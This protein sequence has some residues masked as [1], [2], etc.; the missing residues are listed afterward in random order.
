VCVC[1]SHLE[2]WSK[3]SEHFLEG[4]ILYIVTVKAHKERVCVYVCE[5]ELRGLKCKSDAEMMMFLLPN[6][7]VSVLLNR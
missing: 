1:V 2:V 7:R 4:N 3:F 6:R 5:R